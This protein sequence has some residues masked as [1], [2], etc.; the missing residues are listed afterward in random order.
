MHAYV[1]VGTVLVSGIGHVVTH[2]QTWDSR[3]RP[4]EITCAVMA[5]QA[6]REDDGPPK[7]ARIG[8]SMR[9]VT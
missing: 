6:Q 9:V 2:G 3:F 8:G 7:E 1:A 5:L 4:S